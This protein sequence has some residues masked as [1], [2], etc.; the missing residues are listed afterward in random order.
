MAGLPGLL[1]KDGAEGVFAAAL[2]DGTTVAMKIA[3][4]GD[5]ARAAVL[6]AALGHLGVD[7]AALA[8]QMEV[9]IMGHGQPVGVVRALV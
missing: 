1:A 6:L 4:G 9:K 3:D 8:P 7:V 2:P 5:R